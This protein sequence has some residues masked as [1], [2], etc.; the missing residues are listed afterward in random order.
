MA[1]ASDKN[2][3]CVTLSCALLMT[4]KG[5]VEFWACVFKE[6]EARTRARKMNTTSDS[7]IILSQYPQL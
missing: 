3:K 4:P 1:P 6:E 5:N 7:S 2:L